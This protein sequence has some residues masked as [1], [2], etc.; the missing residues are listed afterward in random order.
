MYLLYNYSNNDDPDELI[1]VSN[2]S[3]LEAFNLVL[4]R[5]GS[6]LTELGI[7]FRVFLRKVFL[8]DSIRSSALND[9]SD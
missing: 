6:D 5:S 4:E 2:E 1:V 8:R 7:D 3:G 9:S